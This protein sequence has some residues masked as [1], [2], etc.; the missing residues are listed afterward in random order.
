MTQ[1]TVGV[2]VFALDGFIIGRRRFHDE[3]DRVVQ[4]NAGTLVA[5]AE[6]AI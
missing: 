6:I 2:P 5:A 4:S 1:H 3:D